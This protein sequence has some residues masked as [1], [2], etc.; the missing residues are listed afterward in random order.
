MSGESASEALLRW[1]GVASFGWL[2]VLLVWESVV[3]AHPWFRT[4]RD[5]GRHAAVNV[6]LALLNVLMVA[7]VFA[8]LWRWVADWAALHR[9][10]LLN[11][12]PMGGAVRVVVSLLLLDVWTYF[13]HRICHRVP[14]LWN[15]HRVHH[16]DAAMDVTTGNR[17][18]AVEIALSAL[19]RLPLIPLLGIRFGDLVLY[20]TL[21]QFVVQWQHANISLSPRW[22]RWL[23]RLVVTP[24]MHQVHH[25][26]HQPE[27]DS[28]YASLLSVWDRIFCSLRIRERPETVRIGLDGFDAPAQQTVRALV[29]QPFR[30]GPRDGR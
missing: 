27:T 17:F 14:W 4:W 25:S 13:W 1:R 12:V 7:V 9:F 23:R 29:R 22:E 20:E 30:A 24:G 5:R 2:V 11:W 6:V 10:G 8:A 18:H 3:P 16:T 15:V 26:R 28:N 21:L 19:L